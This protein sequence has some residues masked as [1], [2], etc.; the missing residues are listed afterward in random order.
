MKGPRTVSIADCITTLAGYDAILDAR[1]PAEFAIDR[2]PEAVSAPVLDDAERAEV[3]TLHAREGAFAAR[4]RGAALVAR[5]IGTLLE[6]RFAAMPSD[7]R[8]LVYCWRGGNRS[9]ALALVLSR[10]GWRV[11]VLEGG[12]RAYRRQV[13]AD[14]ESL[15][16]RHRFVVV[17]GRTGVGKSRLLGLLAERGLQVLDLEGL[18]AHRGSV[19][20][21][22]P[23][24]PQPS[25]KAF[26]SGLWRRLRGYDDRRPIFVE[27]ESRKIGRCQVPGSLIE[28]MRASECIVLTASTRFRTHLLREEYRHF[29]VDPGLL[30]TRLSALAPIHGKTRVAHWDSQARSGNWDELVGELLAAHYDPAYD[31]SMARNFLR[32]ESAPSI[33]ADADADPA[34]SLAAAA[35]RIAALYPAA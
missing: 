23:G 8:P 5:N 28:R 29:L 27:S 17:A 4:R 15:P 19:L 10:I 18:A 34:S 14:L 12:Y 2:L 30:S 3:G 33:V 16:Q 1:S 22:I 11:D 6:T 35:D 26:E 9:G 31:R 20:G 32:L 13:V 25:Q 21:P 7:W 24:D